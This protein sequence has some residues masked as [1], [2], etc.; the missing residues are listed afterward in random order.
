M[1]SDNSLPFF[2]ILVP[3][4]NRPEYL[5]K[6]LKSIF[7]SSFKDFEVIISDDCSPRIIDVRSSIIEYRNLINYY[8][9][10]V[11]LGERK[12]KDF[13][14]KSAKGKYN[15]I[16]GDDDV[17]TSNIL[18]YIY[19]LVIAN[20]DIDIF[21]FG[22]NCIDEKSNLIST[23]KS[24]SDFKINYDNLDPIDLLAFDFFPLWFAHPNTFCCRSGVELKLGYDEDVGIGED[25][26]F[27]L[28]LVLYRYNIFVSS[29]ILFN[30]RKFSPNS[31]YLQSNQSSSRIDE[32]IARVKIC[33]WLKH[34]AVNLNLS[35]ESLF[36]LFKKI[37]V[38]SLILC[39][40]RALIFKNIL[41]LH[42]D[43]LFLLKP[44][45][46]SV[47][48]KSSFSINFY[49][50]VYRTQMLFRFFKCFGFRFTICFILIRASNFLFK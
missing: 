37:L 27:I 25:M 41:F 23:H 1:N 34:N 24:C 11:N 2:S 5:S 39:N 30:W 49:K 12:N 26:L 42:D 22:Y 28:R 47:L 33:K 4:Y 17:F 18:A 21:L 31:K 20:Q 50:Y 10:P 38:P 16:I 6:L 9:Q 15:I 3:S 35:D 36:S 32:F 48:E 46:F 43:F 7:D 29:L 44:Y 14:I 40:S 13:L 45:F 19:N 8:E